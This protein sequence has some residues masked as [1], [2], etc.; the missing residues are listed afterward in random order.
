L[1]FGLM[2][3]ALTCHRADPR[4]D[5]VT[6]PRLDAFDDRVRQP[7]AFRRAKAVGKQQQEQGLPARR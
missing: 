6:D 3:D 1:P 7:L 4:T 5:R 2:I